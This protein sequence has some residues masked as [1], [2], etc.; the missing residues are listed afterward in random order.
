MIARRGALAAIVLSAVMGLPGTA[1][2]G[3]CSKDDFAAV[4][5]EASAVL[6]KL[7]DDNTPRFQAGLRQL[8]EKKGWSDA[9]FI[10]NARP[11]VQDDTIQT[12]DEGAAQLLVQINTL[13]DTSGAAVPDCAVL[14][15]LKESMS[16][17]VVGME[18]KWTYMFKKLQDALAAP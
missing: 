10:A 1:M 3:S 16:R 5:D 18:G 12:Y 9:D 7:N 11:F 2:A 17:L 14:T 15:K 6:R 4:V 13:G 8:K